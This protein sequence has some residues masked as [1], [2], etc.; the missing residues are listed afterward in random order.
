MEA[1]DTYVLGR[2]TNVGYLCFENDSAIVDGIANIFPVF[3][4]LVAALVCSTTMNRMVEEQ[5]TQIGVL[6]ALGYGKGVIMSK[7][8]FY[9]GAAALTGCAAG[10]FGGTWLFPRI[11]WSAYGIMYR[12]EK[13]VYV[14]SPVLAVISLAA[15]LLCTMGVTYLTCRQELSEVAAE[16]MR[17]KAPKAGKRVLLE[18]IPFIW[19]RMSFL[20]KVSVR[21]I[22]RYKKRLFMMVVGIS[23]CT[24]L[25]VTGFGIKDSIAGIAEQQF[26]EIQIYDLGLTLSENITEETKQEIRN[27]AGENMDGMYVLSE[28]TM[29]L[30]SEIGRKSVNVVMA[31][32]AEDIGAYLNLHT[33]EREPLSYPEAGEAVVTDK[34]AKELGINPGDTVSLQDEE[35]NTVSVKVAGISRNFIYNYV[36]IDRAAYAQQMGQEPEN[37]SVWMNLR[38]DAD[39]HQTA[40][41]LMQ[42]EEVS[43]VTVNEDMKERFDSMMSSLDLIVAFI[44]LCAGGLAFIV[45]YNLTNINI[46]ER[47]REIA[48]IKVLG[49]YKKETAAYVFRENAMLTLMGALA[50]LP[51][52]CLLHRFVMSQIQID[53]VAFE[54][55]VTPLSYCLSAVITFVFGWLINRLMRFKLNRVSMTE[56][57]KSVD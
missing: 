33:R 14:F 10:F 1:P 38:E 57:L 17:P 5:R 16:L 27:A 9:A 51:L 20:K 34:V 23:G 29:D 46:T 30:V 4:F 40:A 36:Y 22:F 37:K 39:A 11:I 26:S 19:K 48:T 21:N 32:S 28:T 25:I 2:D 41:A 52:G 13:L 7:Y 15:A 56:S 53:M 6:K 43:N 49:F 31:D 24:A 12:V 3:F 18:K 44:I 35:Q 54:T 42:V 47:V 50:G 8:L 45:L 55:L